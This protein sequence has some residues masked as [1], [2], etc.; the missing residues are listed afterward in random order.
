MVDRLRLVTVPE[1]LRFALAM[2]VVA[3]LLLPARS[4]AASEAQ[5]DRP[6]GSPFELAAPEPFLQDLVVLPQPF[7]HPQPLGV[8]GFELAIHASSDEPDPTSLDIPPGASQDT[9]RAANLAAW[10]GRFCLSP[11]CTRTPAARIADTLAF[12]GAILG[13]A[14][15]SRRRGLQRG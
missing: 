4:E 12:G 3:A 11:T 8:P 1:F 7:G 9:A 14:W 2:A 13:V 15:L 6:E 10:R 5:R